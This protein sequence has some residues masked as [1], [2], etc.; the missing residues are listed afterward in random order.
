MENVDY[1]DVR[2][3]GNNIVITFFNIVEDGDEYVFPLE[4][5]WKL[6]RSLRQ[7]LNH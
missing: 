3:D 5:A 4:D 6:C 1:Y 2:R 7:V